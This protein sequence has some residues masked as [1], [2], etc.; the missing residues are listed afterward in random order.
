MALFTARIFVGYKQLP[1]VDEL[2]ERF[3]R[4]R[5]FIPEP[6]DTNVLFSFYAQ[7]YNHQF[8]RTDRTRG[9]GFT[10]GNDGVS[11]AIILIRSLNE[12]KSV[13]EIRW[14]CPTFT[15]WINRR[16]MLCD[17]S[18]AERW[19]CGQS[20]A[21]ISLPS[22]VMFLLWKWFTRLTFRKMKGYEITRPP[23]FL[24]MSQDC[25]NILRVILH[26]WRWHIRCLASNQDYT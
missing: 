4:R 8:F 19:K 13:V 18:V 12:L 14:M 10:I 24:M 25:F 7:H 1:N 26:R 5:Q 16:K 11:R 23:Q 17:L 20:L 9:P 22:Y 15:D 2:A 6:H 21:K 3:F